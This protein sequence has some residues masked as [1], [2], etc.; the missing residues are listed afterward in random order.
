[1]KP[2]IGRIVH[3]TDREYGT[4]AAIV[5]KVEAEDDT[6]VW[7]TAFLPEKLP[8]FLTVPVP[9]AETPT[10]GHWSWPPRQP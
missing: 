3:F 5:T 7:L 8:G 9:H 10:L 1:M 2:S 6:R 4:V